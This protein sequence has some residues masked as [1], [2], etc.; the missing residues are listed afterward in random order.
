MWHKIQFLLVCMILT[1]NKPGEVTNVENI[2]ADRPKILR[3]THFSCIKDIKAEK[4]VVGV[5]P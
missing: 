2:K 4:L 1:T 3:P 5:I